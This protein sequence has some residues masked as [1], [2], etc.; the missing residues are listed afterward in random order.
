MQIF[1][2]G[3]V[4]FLNLYPRHH[5]LDQNHAVTMVS[6]EPLEAHR[7]LQAEKKMVNCSNRT[8]STFKL[9]IDTI[10]IWN[11]KSDF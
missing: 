9:R 10:F 1:L 4:M 3:I 5:R 8:F 2:D 11:S 7:L 6:R